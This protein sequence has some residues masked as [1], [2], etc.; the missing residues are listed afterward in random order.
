MKSF[1]R[2]TLVVSACLGHSACRYDGTIIR[3]DLVK[4]LE[5]YADL[6]FICPEVEIGLPIPRDSL[7]IVKQKDGEKRLV[8]SQT[9]KDLTDAMNGFSQKFLEGLSQPI[10]GFLLKHRSPSCGTTDVKMYK[11]TGKSHMIPGK[12]PGVF[13]E[14]VK[15]WFPGVAVEN[16]GRLRH[17]N[18]RESFYISIFT[19]K[20]FEKA[21]KMKELVAFHSANKYL[22]MALSPGRL[23]TLGR[24]VANHEKLPFKEV[25]KDYKPL[26]CEMLLTPMDRKR[27]VN[28]LL[29]VYGYF[30]TKIADREKI[31]F[32]ENLELYSEKK[33]P[34]SVLLSLLRS[35][36]IRFEEPYLKG[37]TLFEPFPKKLVDVT[38]SGKGL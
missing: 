36:V 11:G 12:T 5:E 18:I 6:I 10:H 33:V 37:Q 35:W 21:N 26:L 20:A 28:V 9:G 2:P 34:F 4:I 27:N 23:K 8:V 38:D 29:H 31:Y 24:I 16:E 22:F 30:K 3:S 1:D 14:K 25:I 19:L 32:L 7:R 17:F 13:T 15:E